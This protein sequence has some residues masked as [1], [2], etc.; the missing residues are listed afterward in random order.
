M[1]KTPLIRAFANEIDSRAWRLWREERNQLT[2]KC[3]AA[4]FIIT[5]YFLLMRCLHERKILE[6]PFNYEYI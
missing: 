4:A 2:I 3:G 5:D 1:I 6:L